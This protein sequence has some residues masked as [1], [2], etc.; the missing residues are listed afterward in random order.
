[1]SAKPKLKWRVAPAPSGMYRSF[2]KREWPSAEYADGKAAVNL[3]CADDYRPADA[4]SGSHAP[5]TI[6][7]ADYSVSPWRWRTVQKRAAT[8]AEAKL[9]A[10]AVLEQHSNFVPTETTQS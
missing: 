7:V 10:L 5:L 8:L 4:R 9:R 6:H 2:F 1:M 3:S